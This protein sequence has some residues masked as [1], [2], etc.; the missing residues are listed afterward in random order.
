MF[1]IPF[2]ALL[3][4]ILKDFI[5]EFNVIIMLLNLYQFFLITF[6][7]FLLI[8]INTFMTYLFFNYSYYNFKLFNSSSSIQILFLHSKMIPNQLLFWLILVLLFQLKYIILN[9]VKLNFMGT[10]IHWLGL[11]IQS[12]HLVILCFNP[13]YIF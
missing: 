4:W 7:L 9:L 6:Y 5:W 12:N 1:I 2:I 10:H 3:P 8:F 13:F 11:F